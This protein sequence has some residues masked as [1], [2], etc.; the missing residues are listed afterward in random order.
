MS[1]SSQR[2]PI[3]AHVE[4]LSAKTVTCSVAAVDVSERQVTIEMPHGS[5]ALDT[6]NAG[7]P[8]KIQLSPGALRPAKIDDGLLGASG[9]LVRRSLGLWLLAITGTLVALRARRMRLV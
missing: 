6:I 7:D 2:G 8:V 4:R 3:A 1:R 5:S 9:S